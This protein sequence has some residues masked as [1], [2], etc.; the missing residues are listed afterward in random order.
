MLRPR[1][2]PSRPPNRQRNPSRQS[3]VAGTDDDPLGSGTLDERAG[4]GVPVDE[5]LN[6]RRARARQDDAA[7]DT[8]RRNDR[9]VGTNA[10]HGVPL[11]IVIVRNSGLAPPAMT[12]AAVV[13]RFAAGLSSSSFCSVRDLLRKT[14]LLLQPDLQLAICCFSCSLSARTCCSAK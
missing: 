5:Q 11:S 12:L 13:D 8:G 2:P 7:D 9:H 6:L 3:V 1:P 14:A 10:R 4:G